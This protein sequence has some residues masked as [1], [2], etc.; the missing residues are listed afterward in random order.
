VVLP[1]RSINSLAIHQPK[2]GL[3]YALKRHGTFKAFKK[4]KWN[5]CGFAHLGTAIELAH[6]HCIVPVVESIEMGSGKTQEPMVN[7]CSPSKALSKVLGTNI[8]PN[9][10]KS[11]IQ[12]E[13]NKRI[14]GKPGL[15][16]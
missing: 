5:D 4:C 3:R 10:T 14:Y 1:C 12:Y 13:S 15:F 9:S 11:P 7:S 2:I 8:A 6:L 16:F